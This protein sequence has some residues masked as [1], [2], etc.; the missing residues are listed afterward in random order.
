VGQLTLSHGKI[1]VLYLSHQSSLVII[2]SWKSFLLIPKEKFALIPK[3]ASAPADWSC[4]EWQLMPQA[5]TQAYLII[6]IST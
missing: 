3:A 4:D 1:L 6:G 5:L 2:V